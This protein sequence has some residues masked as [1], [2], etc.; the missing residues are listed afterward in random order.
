MSEKKGYVPG[1][2]SL[3]L[4]ALLIILLCIV[5]VT[6]V[7]VRNVQNG[8]LLKLCREDQIAETVSGILSGTVLPAPVPWRSIGGCGAGGSGGGIEDGIEW[9]GEGASGGLIDLEVLSRLSISRNLSQKVISSRFSFKPSWTTTLGVTV[10]VMTK[11]GDVILQTNRVPSY[12]STGGLGDI[13]LDLSKDVGF[14]GQFSLQWSLTLPTGQYDIRRGSDNDEYF[15]PVDLQMGS[16]VYS[17][18]LR[19]SWDVDVEDGFWKINAAYTHPFAM[20]LF[21]KENEMLDRYFSGYGSRKSNRRFYYRFKPYGENDLGGYTPPSVMLSGYYAYRGVERYVHSWGVYLSAPLGTAWI[22]SWS[23][24]EY[25]P[26]PD[27]DHFMW[28]GALIYQLEFSRPKYPLFLAVS[29]PIHDRPDTRGVLNGPEWE[30]VLNRW[31][32][33]FG[34]KS[35]MF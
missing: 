23:T 28:N 27:P 14:S 29:L 32:F 2:I 12:H 6:V 7:K 21:T 13:T 19:W 9:L 8:S 24:G 11:N 3:C 4:P 17:S 1:A 34:I 30:D 25:N 20:R 26:E 18:R 5:V 31:I 16:G 22:P 35:T 33:A 15:L 10:P